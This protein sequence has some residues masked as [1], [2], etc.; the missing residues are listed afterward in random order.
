[1]Q[2]EYLKKI[3]ALCED[4]SSGKIDTSGAVEKWKQLAMKEKTGDDSVEEEPNDD[5][6]E[7]FSSDDDDV[8]QS[9]FFHMY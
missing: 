1:M 2:N 3:L 6:M 8:S 5:N 9:G 7:D 4:A